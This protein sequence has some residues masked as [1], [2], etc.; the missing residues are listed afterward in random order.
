MIVGQPLPLKKAPEGRVRTLPAVGMGF[1]N[2]N[3]PIAGNMDWFPI[4]KDTPHR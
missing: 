2:E 4:L 1:F 3:H